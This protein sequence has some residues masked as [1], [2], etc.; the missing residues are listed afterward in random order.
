M[1]ASRHRRTHL[2][3]WIRS[4]EMWPIAC[5]LETAPES[6]LGATEQRWIREMKQYGARLTN[7]TAGG[8]GTIGWRHSTE[9][10]DKMRQTAL[11]RSPDVR[12]RMREAQLGKKAS[13]ETRQKMS[14]ARLGKK[15][16]PGYGLVIAAAMRG[17][18]KSAE[19][20]RNLS[21]AHRGQ[22]VTPE[23]REKIS[24]ATRG[25]PKPLA[26]RQQMSARMM[27]HSVSEA[28][29]QKMSASQ[30]LRFERE[31]GKRIRTEAGRWAS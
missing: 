19:H 14:A 4:L 31:C 17:K 12:Q 16:P 10:R 24:Q 3:C 18:K 2:A 11:T 5:V 30:R 20:R 29:R 7:L 26:W 8:E 22:V 13:I 25:R 23:H 6:L 21:I 28:A 27:G 1:F 9:A 15:R